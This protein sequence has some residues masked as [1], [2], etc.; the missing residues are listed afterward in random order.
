MS[1]LLLDR[2]KI[3]RDLAGLSKRELADRLEITQQTLNN[4][5]RGD[6]DP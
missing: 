2:L 5:E 6:R 3:A 4:Y 1:D